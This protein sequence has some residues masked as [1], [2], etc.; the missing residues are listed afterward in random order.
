MSHVPRID[1]ACLQRL[2]AQESARFASAHPR[3]AQLAARAGG[4]LVGGVP[5]SWMQ[6]WASPVPPY[7]ASA[8]GATITDVDGHRYLDLA[9][10]DT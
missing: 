5:M 8:R 10:G 3:A 9:L 2:F 6:R 1:D 7:A 4:S